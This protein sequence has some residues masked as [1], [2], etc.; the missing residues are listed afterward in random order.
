MRHASLPE[1]V[2]GVNEYTDCR[3]KDGEK[4]LV[5]GAKHIKDDV[6]ESFEGAGHDADR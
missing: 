3:F 2:H 1:Y 5:D 6:K 4:K